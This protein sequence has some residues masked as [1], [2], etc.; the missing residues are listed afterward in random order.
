MDGLAPAQPVR[1]E[2]ARRLV[3]QWDGT[4][5]AASIAISLIGAFTSTQLMCQ[6]KSSRY[7]GGYV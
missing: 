2:E 4:L 7:F 6:A 1:W 5:I 3:P